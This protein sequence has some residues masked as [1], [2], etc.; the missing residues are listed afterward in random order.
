VSDPLYPFQYE[1]IWRLMREPALAAELARL[2]RWRDLASAQG[3]AGRLRPLV[4]RGWLI[5]DE[6]GVYRATDKAR[7]AV[8]W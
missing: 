1:I 6:S 5:R 3:M 4:K 7:K 2:P 8:S